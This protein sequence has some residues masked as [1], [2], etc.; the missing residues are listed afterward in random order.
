MRSI[1]GDVELTE[2]QAQAA[3]SGLK[4]LMPLIG[5]KTMLDFIVE[6]VT[7][8]GFSNICLV[9]G[10]EH[11]AIR[12]F[13]ASRKLP[14]VFAEQPEA[15]GTADAVLASKEFV[16]A[17][18]FLVI[19]SDNL[20]PVDGL[21]RLRA[22]NRPVLLAF[23][24]ANLIEQSNI[25]ADRV[26]SFA[27]V[28]IDA[29]GNLTSIVEKPETVEADSLVSMNAWL[30]SPEIFRACSAIG[31]SAER[32]EYELTAAVQFAIDDLGVKFSAI[33]TGEGVL[34]LSNRGDIDT[35]SAF[36]AG[37]NQ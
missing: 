21:R 33:T 16:G 1:V 37:R 31:P 4:A 25:S 36:L 22:A 12:D 14:V 8:A 11:G 34:D 24:R 9:I 10:P 7:A 29:A 26:A 19:N 23:D 17:E 18:N 6:N 32:G 27:T 28:E 15:K 20:Y 3:N 2:E 5:A 35:A 13:C 30:F